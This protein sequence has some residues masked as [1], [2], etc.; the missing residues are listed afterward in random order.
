MDGKKANNWISAMHLAI[1]HDDLETVKQFHQHLQT[2]PNDRNIKLKAMFYDTLCDFMCK[3]KRD[4]KSKTYRYLINEQGKLEFSLNLTSSGVC[5]YLIKLNPENLESAMKLKKDGINADI[6]C[7]I[8]PD[9]LRKDYGLKP[10]NLRLL[11]LHLQNDLALNTSDKVNALIDEFK[12]DE[13]IADALKKN[14]NPKTLKDLQLEDIL[15]IVP[16]WVKRSKLRQNEYRI[17]SD[18]KTFYGELLER[19][20]GNSRM[21]CKY[22]IDGYH[23]FPNETE[24]VLSCCAKSFGYKHD[25][26]MSHSTAIDQNTSSHSSYKALNTGNSSGSSGGFN[27]DI[28]FFKIGGNRSSTEQSSRQ[29]EDRNSG[30]SSTNRKRIN[31]HAH[32]HE[33]KASMTIESSALRNA[34]QNPGC[35]MDK[36]SV[37][38]AMTNRYQSSLCDSKM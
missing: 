24:K 35:L 14:L 4:F 8:N 38:N 25:S 32:E 21:F 11:D 17:C 5:D 36:C 12:F 2:N 16:S 3:N 10:K 28:G 7:K 1:F 20:Y 27:L 31:N 22:S 6:L 26:E 19:L 37:Y 18:A 23:S 29:E 30:S 33:K 9:D 34:C 13:N 15:E